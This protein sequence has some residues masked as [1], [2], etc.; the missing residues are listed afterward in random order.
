MVELK[1]KREEEIS[2]LDPLGYTILQYEKA[3]QLV[4]SE[5]FVETFLC[6]HFSPQPIE[7]S[8]CYTVVFFIGVPLT[9]I[10]IRTYDIYKYKSKLALNSLSFCFSLQRT[11][12]RSVLYICFEVP[13]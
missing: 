13:F 7:V 1:V 10:I 3:I 5:F 6:Q 9:F 2:I 12:I 8:V 4:K 11:G